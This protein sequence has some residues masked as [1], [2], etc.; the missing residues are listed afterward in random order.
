MVRGRIQAAGCLPGSGLGHWKVREFSVVVGILD[1]IMD[2]C[3][4]V[5]VPD[6]LGG[7]PGFLDRING[8]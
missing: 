4:V 2:V 1:S 3:V 8:F 5:V 7:F 6:F